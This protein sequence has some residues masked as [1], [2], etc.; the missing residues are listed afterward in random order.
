M[1]RRR[2][3]LGFVVLNAV[4]A[5]HGQSKSPS[6]GKRRLGVLWQERRS[7]GADEF[8]Q[9]LRTALA[10]FGWIVGQ[11][12]TI[13]WHFA[14]G[15]LS[16]LPTL[17]A[18]IVRSGPDAILTY[19][20]PATIALQLAT[21]TI[22]IVTGVGDAVGFGLARSYARPGG[23]ITGLSYGWVERQYKKVELLR[24]VAPAVTR[25]IIA[26]SENLAS[27]AQ[28]SSAATMSAAREFG[29]VPEIVLVATAADLQ[30][31]L[32][33]D[34]LSAMIVNG[35]TRPSSPVKIDEVIAFS[36]GNRVPTVVEVS[37]DVVLGGLMSYEL[38]WDNEAQRTAYQL[39]KVL[40]GVNPAQIPF[41]LP[42]R[43]W[44]A[45]NLK[46]ARTIRLALP[47]ALLARAD[48][49]IE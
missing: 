42:T 36:L 29:F 26:L 12:L 48:E 4:G 9:A 5:S 32:Q 2:D 22:P 24:S 35:L 8:A 18:E 33:S 17:A 25:L 44:L 38:Y 23:N 41:E 30:A 45:V 39:D 1:T 19:L 10:E 43:S 49:V 47:K 11:N 31:A 37:E 7:K 28:G 13:E 20:V 46:T 21:K 6:G 3:L 14:D 40:R 16:R 34:R 27:V 15:D